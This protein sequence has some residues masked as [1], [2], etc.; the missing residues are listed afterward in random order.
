MVECKCCTRQLKAGSDAVEFKVASFT[1]ISAVEY[2]TGEPV[3]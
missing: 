1:V 3:P 2:I